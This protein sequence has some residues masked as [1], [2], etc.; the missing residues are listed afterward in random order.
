MRSIYKVTSN[1][2][3]WLHTTKEWLRYERDNYKCK[4][5]DCYRLD[6]S[7][8]PNPI[9]IVIKKTPKQ[10]LICSGV[11][12]SLGRIFHLDFI[13]QI[14]PYMEGFVFG[15]CYLPDKTLVKDYVTCY[16]KDF[17]VVRGAYGSKYI[18]CQACGSVVGHPAK[19]PKYVLN[20]CLR[21]RK[22]FQNAIQLLYIDEDLAMKLD[23]S[24]WVKT[25]LEPIPICDKPVDRRRLLCDTETPDWEYD[26]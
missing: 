17:I 10:N 4:N 23:F 21:G 12:F 1:D 13:E 24:P 2:E 19:E 16:S 15:A 14:K 8:F 11:A 9:D 25:E 18:Q 5:V 3:E 22:V 20:D 7:I 26:E 6:R